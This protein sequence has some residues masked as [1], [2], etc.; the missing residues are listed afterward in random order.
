MPWTKRARRF[1]KPYWPELEEELKN[2][3]IKMRQDQRRISTARIRVQA[4]VIAKR[5]KITNSKYHNFK[6]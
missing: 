2:W 5:L 6:G 1:G 3:V 4:K